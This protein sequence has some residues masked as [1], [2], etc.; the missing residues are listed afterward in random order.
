MSDT[1]LNESIIHLINDWPDC[2]GSLLFETLEE[3]RELAQQEVDG[4]RGERNLQIHNT[5]RQIY[6]KQLTLIEELTDA[7][8]EEDKE[9]VSELLIKLKDTMAD[10]ESIG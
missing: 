6:E 7:M 4:A 5:T 3:Y 8:D 2:D 9:L 1:T 10:G